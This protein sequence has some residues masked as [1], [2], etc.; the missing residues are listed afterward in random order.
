MRKRTIDWDRFTL[1]FLRATRDKLETKELAEILEIPTKRVESRAGSLR[2]MGY[3]LP[4]INA[5]FLTKRHL[6][7]IEEL[8]EKLEGIVPESRTKK[9]KGKRGET[10]SDQEFRL[11]IRYLLMAKRQ[12]KNR[13]WV[14]EQTGLSPSTV[15]NRAHY[16]E[17]E[18]GIKLKRLRVITEGSIDTVI[19]QIERKQYLNRSLPKIKHWNRVRRQREKEQNAN[20]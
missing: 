10:L 8:E 17:I 13:T 5:K 16:I 4:R 7:K 12:K 20:K 3:P 2:K 1:E 11:L 15:S 18:C 19:R 9:N 6:D 14:A